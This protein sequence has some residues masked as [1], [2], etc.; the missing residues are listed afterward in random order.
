MSE[1]TRGN[2]LLNSKTAS[3]MNVTKQLDAQAM[4]LHQ[5]AAKR[6]SSKTIE[7]QQTMS[8]I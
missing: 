4:C 5:Q 7:V 1:V 3:G 6:Y 8:T 2:P